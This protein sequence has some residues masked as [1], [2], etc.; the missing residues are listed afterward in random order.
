MIF[1]SP[2]QSVQQTVHHTKSLKSHNPLPY[3]MIVCNCL[4][5]LLYSFLVRNYYIFFG[6]L[7]GWCLGLYYV[8]SM[9]AVALNSSGPQ[10]SECFS[11]L[12]VLVSGTALSF[13][14]A[15][16]SFIVNFPGSGES[17]PSGHQ[18]MFTLTPCF[19]TLMW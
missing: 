19:I 7:I 9:F 10:S 5:W 8:L 18:G 1:L 17:F 14:G 15:L 3:C 4:A 11:M 6:N 13:L 2:L 16:F 12:A